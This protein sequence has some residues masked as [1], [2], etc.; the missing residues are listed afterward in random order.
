MPRQTGRFKHPIFTSTIFL[1]GSPT[2]KAGDTMTI[3]G[4]GFTTIHVEKKGNPKGKVDISNNVRIL[5][6]QKKDM[7]WSRDDQEGLVFAFEFISGYEPNM[8]IIKL[9]GEVLYLID[10][11]KAKKV[12]DE[13]AKDKKISPEITENVLNTVLTKCN[14]EALILS[15][16][17][18]LPPPIPLPKVAHKV[19]PA[20]KKK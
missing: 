8:G 3:V 12:I 5:S 18:N 4:F 2:P 16:Q 10:K 6:I 7:S 17:I 13:W 9:E 20:V 14:I 1:Y 15:Q 19:E 11:A